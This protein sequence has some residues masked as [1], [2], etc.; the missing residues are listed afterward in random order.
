MGSFFYTTF[1][2]D[3]RFPLLFSEECSLR[4]HVLVH[5]HVRMCSSRRRL[6]RVGG[7]RVV[8]PVASY[9]ERAASERLPFWQSFG[10]YLYRTDSQAD[11]AG[12]DAYHAEHLLPRVLLFE[13]KQSVGKAYD[14]T[15]AAN[16]THY[17]NQAVRIP[18]R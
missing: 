14:R 2:A 11:K 8:E 17:R 6:E 3:L 1:A 10:M 18:Q 5:S 15:A 4:G 16:G 13:E 7:A 12:E 9:S